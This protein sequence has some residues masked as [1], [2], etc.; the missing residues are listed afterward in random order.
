[1]GTT[2]PHVVTFFPKETCSCPSTLTCYHIMALNDYTV[3]LTNMTCK[4]SAPFHQY[5]MT[6]I[7]P[8][9][10]SIARWGIEPCGV[11]N[12]FRGVTH[13]QAE[14]FNHVLT[15]CRNGRKRL[16]TAWHC[17]CIISKCTIHMKLREESKD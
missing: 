4:W 2:K 12:P 1:M 3:A 14:G 16:W 11:Y 10:D 15:I 9:I 8:D 17:L 7:H 6:H 5:Y 13:N